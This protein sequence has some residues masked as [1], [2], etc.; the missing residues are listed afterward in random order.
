MVASLGLASS[1]AP[2]LAQTVQPP[3]RSGQPARP[4]TASP[5]ARPAQ[6]PVSQ[7]APPPAP[8]ATPAL[9]P[10]PFPQGSKFAYVNLQALTSLSVEGKAAATAFQNETKRKQTEAEAKA[11]KMQADQQ[12]LEASGSVM[13]A[14]AR[15]TLEK[16]IERQQREGERFEQDAQAELNDL[17]QKLQAEYNK[18]LFPV[19]EQ[20]SRDYQLQLLF[21]AAES[22]LIWAEP[23][24]D[25]TLEAVKRMDAAPT[26]KPAATPA[27]TPAKP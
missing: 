7:P 12:R 13:S 27:A 3:A 22:G 6:P 24:L 25:L 15:A 2:V 16:D 17:Q 18:K 11:K 8:A 19:L 1:A 20:L 14:D 10:V 4:A 9:P 26:P 21:S 23:G 5:P